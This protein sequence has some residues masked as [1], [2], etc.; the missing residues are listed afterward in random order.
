MWWDESG[1]GYLAAT[2]HFFDKKMHLRSPLLMMKYVPKNEDDSRHTGERLERVLRDEL[3]CLYGESF[4]DR[5]RCAVVDGG[6]NV[7]KAARLLV[8]A[9]RAR[10]CVMHAIQLFIKY[11]LSTIKKIAVAVA[12][13]NYMA[14]RS[15]QSQHFAGFV[16]ENFQ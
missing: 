8:G 14:M 4:F 11:S 6:S 5:V 16:R 1:R 15:N 7:T 10:R 13:A 3:T 12:A 9:P 2:G